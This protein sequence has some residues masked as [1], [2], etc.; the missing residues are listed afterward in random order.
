VNRKHHDPN[1]YSV[2]F[3]LCSA[4]SLV[5]SCLRRVFVFGQLSVVLSSSAFRMP[6]AG[7]LECPC[8]VFIRTNCAQLF[9]PLPSLRVAERPPPPLRTF[10]I[11]FFL[12]LQRVRAQ[13]EGSRYAVVL[14]PTYLVHAARVVIT[15]PCIS[16]VYISFL[17]P[18]LF[19]SDSVLLCSI[20]SFPTQYSQSK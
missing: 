5:V 8:P 15:H 9:P 3:F 17:F 16:R 19:L 14:A 10:S 6:F 4:S 13:C 18:T 2:S 7:G 12:S 11:I 1:N 20:F